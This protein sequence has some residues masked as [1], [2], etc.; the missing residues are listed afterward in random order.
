MKLSVVIPT[1]NRS[2][3]LTKSLRAFEQQSLKADDFE[4]IIGSD[5]STDDTAQKV[6]KFS[7]ASRLNVKFLDLQ[8]IGLSAVRNSCIREAKGEV[9][10]FM[11]DDTMPA[12]PDFLS[13]HYSRVTPETACVG[14]VEWHPEFSKTEV[15]DYLS[16]KGPLFNFSNIK[17]PDNCG[18]HLFVTCNISLH[19]KWFEKELFDERHPF[20]NEDIELGYRL[21]KHGLR[22][23]Y[24]PEVAVFHYH[25]FDDFDDF[26]KSKS[27][28]AVS[29]HYLTEKHPELRKPWY[30]RLARRHLHKFVYPAY[31]LTGLKSIRNFWWT[32]RIGSVLEQK[33]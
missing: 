33:S 27:E 13:R 7:H 2:E 3:I 9:L 5:G 29:Y 24:H 26:I 32:C 20:G 4:I 14:L 1:Y 10:L 23:T 31:K 21:S 12:Q 30:Y 6:K 28:R 25:Y 17:N 19:K 8:H 22:I 11:N 18:W 15:M 16:P